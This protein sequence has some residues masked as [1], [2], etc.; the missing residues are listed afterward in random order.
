MGTRHTLQA[1]GG[2]MQ[3]GSILAATSTTVVT[4]VCAMAL[5]VQRLVSR[6]DL[7][8]PRILPVLG[9]PADVFVESRMRSL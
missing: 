6:F 9:L 4:A 7:L 2:S 1:F 3:L 8:V 5:A